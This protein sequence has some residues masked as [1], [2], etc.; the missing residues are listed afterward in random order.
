MTV[1]WINLLG[2]YPDT[3]QT[4]DSL[5][6]FSFYKQ[7]V[8]SDIPYPPQTREENLHVRNGM[9]MILGSHSK[10]MKCKYNFPRAKQS[11]VSL[12]FTT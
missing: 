3:L 10:R 11:S 8:T 5:N 9:E 6:E 12:A 2:E 1:R 4:W 7:E